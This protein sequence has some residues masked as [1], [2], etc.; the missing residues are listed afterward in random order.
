MAKTKIVYELNAETLERDFGIKSAKG[1]T[2]EEFIARENG[3][4]DNTFSEE[5]LNKKLSE[6]LL[7]EAL[8]GKNNK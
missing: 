8:S 3:N 7:K 1:L 5:N 4:P 6:V 2:F